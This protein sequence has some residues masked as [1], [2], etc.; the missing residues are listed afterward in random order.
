M[1]IFVVYLKER[2]RKRKYEFLIYPKGGA[3][4]GGGVIYIVCMPEK[5]EDSRKETLSIRS[6]GNNEN[7][8]EEGQSSRTQEN[9]FNV[10]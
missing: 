9:F 3:L 7:V 2:K 1:F 5:E 8:F 10:L 4:W 6:L